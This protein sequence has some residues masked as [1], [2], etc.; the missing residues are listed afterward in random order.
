MP[1]VR[2]VPAVRGEPL[3][4]KAGERRP[5]QHVLGQRDQVD[6]RLG[7]ATAIVVP[8]IRVL[9]DR[10]LGDRGVDEPAIRPLERHLH[11]LDAGA[12]AP[13]AWVSA[14]RVS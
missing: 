4:D 9:G 14:G 1:R 5:L 2:D 8:V 6:F 10:D 12:L 7:I 11:G 13:D 3:D